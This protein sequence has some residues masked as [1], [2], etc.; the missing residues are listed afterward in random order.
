MDLPRG[1]MI[2]PGQEAGLMRSRRCVSIVLSASALA[3]AALLVA[4]TTDAYTL[5]GTNLGLGARDVRVFDNFTDPEANDNTT[6][7]PNW[8]GVDSAP[9]ALWK[10]VAEWSSVLH[11]DGSGDPSQPGDL[12]SGGANFDVEW[13]GLAQSPGG[14]GDNTMSEIAGCSGGVVSFTET[15]AGGWRMRFYSCFTF[16]DGPS[17]PVAGA[18]DLQGLVTHEYGH[19]LGLGHSNAAGN[20]TMAATLPDLVAARSIEADDRAGI[21]AIYGVAAVSK[22]RIRALAGHFPIWILGHN[23]APT[24]NVVRFPAGDIPPTHSTDGGTVILTSM[25]V[26]P[27]AGDVQVQI[28]T[29]SGAELSNGWPF[30]PNACHRPSTYCTAKVN[31]QGCTPVIDFTGT[32]SASAPGAFLISA[33]NVINQKSGVLFYGLTPA[34]IPFQGGMRC[35]TG[36]L[37][38]TA[39]Q[40]SGGN[41]LPA[42]CSGTLSFDMNARIQSGVDAALVPGTAVFAQY[43][44]RDPPASFGAGLTDA[45]AFTICP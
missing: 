39:I 29:T 15:G 24:G 28:G 43:V 20:P 38:R 35:A 2:D 21:Q 8:P 3:G 34:A 41:P 31:S 9:L 1:G 40:S 30:E 13:E 10:G 14:V 26:A 17:A 27:I 18:I 32:P 4:S 36:A 42:D 44:Y 7:D 22:P 19:L 11:G 45:V 37:R 12:G 5:T 6:L 23:F 16:D 25:P 33:T